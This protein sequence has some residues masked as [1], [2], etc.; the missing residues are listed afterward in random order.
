[1]KGIAKVCVLGDPAVGK[2]SLIRRAVINVF[3]EEYIS[4]IGT[5]I[6][7]KK[8]SLPEFELSLVIWDI[9]GQPTFKN[10]S[11]DYVK[12]ALGAFVVCDLTRLQTIEHLSNW[13]ALI[14][15]EGSEFIILGNKYDLVEDYQNIRVAEDISSSY[16]VPY[17]TTS[18]KTGEN[19]E[20]AIVT[21]A[22]KIYER[23]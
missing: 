1:M 17:I 5:N 10:L 2:T 20:K 16:N 22:K 15:K 3:E 21:L 8:V 23:M 18:A 4:T 9:A 12:G 11:E 13:I 14:Q 7:E 19:V 6:Y